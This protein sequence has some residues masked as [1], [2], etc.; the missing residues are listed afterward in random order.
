MTFGCGALTP[1]RWPKL[2]T[3][4]FI[5]TVTAAGLILMRSTLVF[6]DF[7]AALDHGAYPELDAGQPGSAA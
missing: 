4:R 6:Q 3:G 2:I 1:S 7:I 5:G